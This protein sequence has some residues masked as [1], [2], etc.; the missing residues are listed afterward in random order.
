MRRSAARADDALRAVSPDIP[1]LE[2]EGEIGPLVDAFARARES[3]GSV[4]AIEAA[5]GLGKSR[6]LEEARWLPVQEG[7]E[8]LSATARGLERNFSLGVARQLLEARMAGAGDSERKRLFAGAAKL[9]APVMTGG[10]PGPRPSD[11][12]ES[13]L[14]VAHGLYWLCSNL[15]ATRPLVLAVDDAQWVDDPSLRFLLYLARRIREIP[16]WSSSRSAGG[17]RSLRRCGSFSPTRRPRC[18]THGR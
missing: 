13:G 11:V 18:C 4:V 9:A 12:E 8:V 14:A 3:R 5:P 16:W 7:M 2:R 6:L 15:S 1:M 17:T 10:L